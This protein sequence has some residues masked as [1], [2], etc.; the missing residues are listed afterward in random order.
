M[1]RRTIIITLSALLIVLTGCGKVPSAQTPTQPQPA[2]VPETTTPVP[3]PSIPVVSTP[4]APASSIQPLAAIQF[5]DSQTGWAVGNGQI[6]GTTDGGKTWREQERDS[7]DYSGVDFADANNGWAWGR[8][9]FMV[10]RDGGKTWKAASPPSSG[11]PSSVYFTSATHGWAIQNDALYEAA[12]NWQKVTTP[13]PVQ[14][15]CFADD[16][17]GWAA[18][19]KVVYQTRDGGKTWQTAFTADLQNDNWRLAEVGCS[20]SSAWVLYHGGA[21][22]SKEAYVVFRTMDAGATWQP[23][24]KNPFYS[25]AYPIADAVQE[26]I[27]AYSGTF[28]VISANEAVFLG[29]C[30]ACVAPNTLSLTT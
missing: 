13:G 16:A 21:G 5:I 20:G 4:P 15:F 1:Y 12:P 14:S 26:P 23:V 24:L 9:V 10:T 8:D 17:R 22:M 18:G 19:G 2:A 27:D 25:S 29:R 11:V 7:A 28:Q 30:P 3:A 6:I